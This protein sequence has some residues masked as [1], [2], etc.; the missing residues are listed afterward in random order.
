MFG[1]KVDDEGILFEN[2]GRGSTELQWP[3]LSQCF[4]STI[5]PE[6]IGISF[7]NYRISFIMVEVS[8]R[9]NS[10]DSAELERAR[11]NETHMSAEN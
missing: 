7:C 5:N 11:N 10:G 3:E 2:T 6:M 9:L 8:R 1:E 4:R